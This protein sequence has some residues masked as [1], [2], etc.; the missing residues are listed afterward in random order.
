MYPQQMS[1][2]PDQNPHQS[3]DQ[4]PYNYVEQYPQSVSLD[5]LAYSR[6]PEE[7]DYFSQYNQPYHYQQSDPVVQQAQIAAYR[8]H[9]YHQQQH[10]HQQQ[11]QQRYQLQYHFQQ[12]QLLQQQLI[13]QNQPKMNS[14]IEHYKSTE[15]PHEAAPSYCKGDMNDTK[16]AVDSTDT[17]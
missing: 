13:E 4:Y 2:F 3:M 17:A 12:Q 11:Q 5:S 14:A 9:Q 1:F 6:S 10:Y 8:L 16:V 7:M 15:L